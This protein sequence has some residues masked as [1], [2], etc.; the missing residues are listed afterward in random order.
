LIGIT[1]ATCIDTRRYSLSRVRLSAKNKTAAAVA[2][3]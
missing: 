3:N 2:A 1:H